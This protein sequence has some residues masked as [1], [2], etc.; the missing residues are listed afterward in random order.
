MPKS[1]VSNLK[2]Y[3]QHFL[4]EQTLSTCPSCSASICGFEIVLWRCSPWRGSTA[5]MVESTS[6]QDDKTSSVLVFTTV[7]GTSNL[8][9]ELGVSRG[10]RCAIDGAVHQ[11]CSGM[12][13]LRWGGWGNQGPI[14]DD[15][16]KGRARKNTLLT[17]S[18]SAPCL[19]GGV[20][21][22]D[23]KHE[24]ADESQIWTKWKT[25]E[26]HT[27]VQGDKSPFHQKSPLLRSHSCPACL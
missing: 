13:G 2:H 1:R 4:S 21:Q 5:G 17:V 18:H 12:A 8:T 26:P 23:H 24:K 16:K 22:C 3:L 11:C 20:L 10:R 19:A 27:L 15:R 9:A 14:E 7:L 6:R 25:Q